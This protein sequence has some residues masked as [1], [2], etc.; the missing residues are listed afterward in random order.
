MIILLKGLMVLCGI[1][2]GSYIGM[3]ILFIIIEKIDR[4]NNEK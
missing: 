2:V 3:K 4:I 1:L